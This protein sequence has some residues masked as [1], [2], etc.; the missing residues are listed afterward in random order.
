[1]KE[2]MREVLKKAKGDFERRRGKNKSFRMG[3]VVELKE[4]VDIT[5]MTFTHLRDEDREAGLRITQKSKAVVVTWDETDPLRAV[6]RVKWYDP[7]KN[8]HFLVDMPGELLNLVH[9]FRIAYEVTLLEDLNLVHDE[10]KINEVM[11]AGGRDKPQWN[12]PRGGSIGMMAVTGAPALVSFAVPSL[13]GSEHMIEL[14]IAMPPYLLAPVVSSTGPSDY[15]SED[16][17]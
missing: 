4:S 9:R 6:A 11:E 1:M 15:S 7:P 10:V 2:A 8:K 16:D 13:D 14:F 17:E 3:D 12:P 5:S